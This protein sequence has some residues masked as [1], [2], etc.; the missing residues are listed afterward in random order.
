ML[1]G[2]PAQKLGMTEAELKAA[3]DSGKTIE[4]IAEEKGIDLPP[5]PPFMGGMH[6]ND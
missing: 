3:M 4:Q 1:P 6:E 2:N 5:R